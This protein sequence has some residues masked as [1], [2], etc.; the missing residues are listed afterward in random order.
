M[1][2]YK[3]YKTLIPDNVTPIWAP[4]EGSQSVVLDHHFVFELLYHG[5]RGPGKSDTLL[6]DFLQ[7]IGRGWGLQYKGV[8]FR[9]TFP[10]LED[11]ITKSKRWIP[12]L[13]PDAKWNGSLYKWVFAT[14][15]ELLFRQFNKPDDYWKY[16]GQEFQFIGWDELT[17]WATLEGYISMMSCLR[18]TNAEIPLR[19]RAT[20]NPYGPGHNVV[21]FH[22]EL[23][24][25]DGIIRAKVYEFED[26]TTREIVRMKLY[27][28]AIKGTVWENTILLKAQPNY[29][30]QLKEQADN[31]AKIAAWLE[32]SW[33]IVAGG[34]FDDVWMPKYNVLR[35]FNIPETWRVDRSFDWGS[36]KPFSVGWWAQSNGEDYQDASGNWRSSVKGDL[37]RI[38]EWYGW[39][40]KPNEGLR[41]LNRDIARGIRERDHILCP[42]RRVYAGPADNQITEIVNG[43]SIAMDMAKQVRLK[44]NRIVSGVTWTRSDKAK[45]SRVTGW[46][47]IRA[48]MQNAHPTKG[49]REHP[50]LFVFDNCDQFIRTVPVLPRCEKNPDDVNSDAEDHIADEV[51]YRVLSEGRQISSGRTVGLY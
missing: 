43:T 50:G 17:N 31:P 22:F 13:F 45:G 49:P 3:G 34:M 11:L 7:F 28:L 12:Q 41:M 19:C 14:G 39:N 10:Q 6:M 29:I 27:R 37:F 1:L 32:G 25:K 5:S 21:K 33:D 8:I 16:H 42:N 44:N 15:E 20:A 23:P 24:A 47:K 2:P 35:R 38:A 51:R 9:Q 4:L 30:A 18:T 26:P 48:M 36:S 40:G 46:E